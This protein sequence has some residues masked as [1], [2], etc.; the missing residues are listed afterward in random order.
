MNIARNLGKGERILR[1]AI[2]IALIL[3]GFSVAG[4]W[5]ILLLVVGL[6]LVGTAA[7]GY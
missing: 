1:T 4:G 5:K 6:G 3:W 7:L 2:G